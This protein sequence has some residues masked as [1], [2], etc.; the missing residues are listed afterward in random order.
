M[1]MSREESVK[2]AVDA[3]RRNYGEEI[4]YTALVEELE[5]QGWIYTG[6]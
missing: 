4:D 2:D 3:A 1:T 6:E 5:R